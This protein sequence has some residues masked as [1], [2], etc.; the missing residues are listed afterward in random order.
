MAKFLWACFDGGGNVP[1]SLGIARSLVERGHEVVFAGRPEMAQRVEPAGFRAVRLAQSYHHADEYGWH[2]RGRLFSYLTSPAVGEELLDLAKAENPQAVVIDAMFG[3]ALDVAPR[4][5][6]PTAVMLH[7]FLHRTFEGWQVLM[8][9][10]SETRERSGFGPLPSLADMWST[11]DLFHANSLEQLDCAPKVRWANVRH[12][13]PILADD[14]RA[15]PVAAAPHD[16]DDSQPLVLV[17]FSTEPEQRSVSKLQRALYGLADLPVSVLAT[18]GGSVDPDELDVPTNA[19]VVRFATHGPLMAR[20]SLVVTHGGHGTTMR[21][22]SYGVPILCMTG[23]AADQKGVAALDQPCVAAF[24][25]ERGLG[26]GLTADVAPA[27]IRAAAAE[28][29]E[30]PLYRANAGQVAAALHRTNGAAV[31]ADRIIALAS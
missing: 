31:A 28:L 4:F 8:R 13:G 6:L 7:T 24:L 26:R 11:T 19:T 5:G 15:V 21:A 22:L 23:Q 10:E 14:P 29:I 18:T 2:P 1:P 12:G 27:D 20:A 25:E 16:R 3:G 30:N 17:S 9:G